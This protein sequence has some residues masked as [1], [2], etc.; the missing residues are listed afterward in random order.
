MF[1]LRQGSVLV[2]GPGVKVV[3]RKQG[4]CRE[5]HL[6]MSFAENKEAHRLLVSVKE[7]R[8]EVSCFAIWVGVYVSICMSI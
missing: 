2:L 6:Q 8:K 7:E 3:E 4:Q 1:F 5:E